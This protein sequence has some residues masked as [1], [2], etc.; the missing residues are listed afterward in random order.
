[1]IPV[2]ACGTASVIHATI[3]KKATARA[4]LG[5][6]CRGRGENHK[7]AG[8][9]MERAPPISFRAECDARAGG[10]SKSWFVAPTQLLCLCRKKLRHIVG[11]HTVGDAVDGVDLAVLTTEGNASGPGDAARGSFDH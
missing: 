11:V 8:S 9:R 1:M 10:E 6:S 5:V 4:C 2:R 7:M 3:M